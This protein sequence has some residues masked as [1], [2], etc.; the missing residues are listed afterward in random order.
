MRWLGLPVQTERSG[1][2]HVDAAAR[3]RVQNRLAQAGVAGY[4][5]V[6]PTATLATKQWSAVKFA[7]LGDQLHRRWGIRVIYTAAAHERATLQAIQKAASCPHLYWSDLPLDD[8]LALIDGCR[9][10]VGN[11]SG[12]T[13]VA[14]AL[15]RPV[16]VIWGS[17]NFQAWRPWGVEYEAVRSELP[18]MPC[19]GYTC[20]AFGAPKCILDIT[21]AQVVDACHRLLS[22]T[23]EK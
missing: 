10:F 7:Q 21:V 4:F 23:S 19:P 9:L 2:I 18:C 16:V 1:S 14:S 17:S 20:G 6:Q 22:R 13:H 11:D 5:L 15:H 3:N 8:L 12:P